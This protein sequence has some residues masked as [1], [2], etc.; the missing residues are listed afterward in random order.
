MFGG[1]RA[2]RSGLASDLESFNLVR[3][4]LDHIQHEGSPGNV[5]T[6]LNTAPEN[7][8][9]FY[10]LSLSH[11]QT[12]K[13]SKT[14][15]RVLAWILV[16]KQQLRLAE[17]Q[18]AI[19]IDDAKPN[20]DY[21]DL[22]RFRIE[23]DTLLE[24]CA[25]LVNSES[26]SKIF[27]FAH[28]TVE[29]YLHKR[30]KETKEPNGVFRFSPEIMA[31]TLSLD[32]FTV[33][34]SDQDESPD[35]EFEGAA[36]DGSVV[37][38]PRSRRARIAQYSQW[39]EIFPYL[40]YAARNWLEFIQQAQDAAIDRMVIDLLLDNVK[41]RSCIEIMELV[42]VLPTGLTMEAPS[43]L[44]TA[45][46]LGLEKIVELLLSGVTLGLHSTPHHK[47]W[48]EDTQRQLTR[49]IC[50]L[51]QYNHLTHYNRHYRMVKLFR[52]KL[53]AN[54]LFI[55]SNGNNHLH[56][57]AL[58]GHRT[59]FSKRKEL[60]DLLISKGV[61]L[62]LQNSDG[63]TPFFSAV[64]SQEPQMVSHILLAGADTTAQSKSGDNLLEFARV[65]VQKAA[66]RL[67]DYKER[68]RKDLWYDITRYERDTIEWRN[69]DTTTIQKMVEHYPKGTMPKEELL[70]FVSDN[71]RY[72]RN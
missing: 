12:S 64:F 54:P 38:E 50:A 70:R 71:T 42:G 65:Q 34:S 51:S 59:N 11:V 24:C 32:A 63:L 19:A 17:L 56:Y 47:A 57:V 40:A 9:G 72:W 46:F 10:S 39:L 69:M 41:V 35:D 16:A 29:E 55:D 48:E 33:W 28:R 20:L 44:R 31:A 22:S 52:E 43:A 18:D 14:G 60:F 37:E 30:Q 49:L 68:Q 4:L 7:L 36:V 62:D 3:L 2:R 13:T 58:L 67:E 1:V 27:K 25:G 61:E 23:P 66:K 15:L 26:S 21:R 6:A 5:Q 45:T 53:F 8:D